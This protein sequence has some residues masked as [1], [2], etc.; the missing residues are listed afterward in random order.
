MLKIYLAVYLLLKI[1]KKNSKL[2]GCFVREIFE[3]YL[4][5]KCLKNGHSGV[6]NALAMVKRLDD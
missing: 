3:I 2:S 4:K 6:E 1:L 5:K